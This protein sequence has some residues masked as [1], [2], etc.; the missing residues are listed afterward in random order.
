MTILSDFGHNI[1]NGGGEELDKIKSWQDRQVL[2]VVDATIITQAGARKNLK[3]KQ[4]NSMEGAR[5]KQRPFIRR[6]NQAC[7]GKEIE[8]A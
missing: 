2:A 8:N 5:A 3:T 7:Y 1:V 6:T 4:L